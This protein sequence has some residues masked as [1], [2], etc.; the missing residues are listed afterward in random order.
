M[1]I[2][3]PYIGY[4]PSNEN[5]V[6][7]AIHLNE[8]V[9]VAGDLTK[10]PQKPSSAYKNAHRMTADARFKIS[11]SLRHIPTLGHDWQAQCHNGAVLELY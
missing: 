8:F 3:A 10:Y 5:G 11:G 6:R 2:H 7:K 1:R 4:L 9:G